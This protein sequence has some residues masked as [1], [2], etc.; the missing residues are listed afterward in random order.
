MANTSLLIPSTLNADEISNTMSM[1]QIYG[2]EALNT[3]QTCFMARPFSTNKTVNLISD[4]VTMRSHDDS[5]TMNR[6][7]SIPSNS[8]GVIQKSSLLLSQWKR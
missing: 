6:M 8:T 2:T 5:I 7:S 3:N 4:T 1:N